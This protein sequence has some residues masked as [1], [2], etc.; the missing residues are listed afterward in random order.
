MSSQ[1]FAVLVEVSVA[2]TLV[3]GSIFDAEDGVSIFGDTLVRVAEVGSIV[4]DTG[5]VSTFGDTFVEVSDVEV[6]V[7]VWVVKVDSNFFSSV[8][9][10]CMLLKENS[11]N[12]IDKNDNNNVINFC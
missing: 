9:S 1:S 6:G 7:V 8:A 12:N 5:I 2:D 4:D 11:N 3:G 10:S